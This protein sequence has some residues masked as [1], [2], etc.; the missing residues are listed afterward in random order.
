MILKRIFTEMFNYGMVMVATSNRAPD[1]LYKN[2]LQRVNFLP[3]IPILKKHCDVI[4]IFGKD[5]RLSIA[6]DKQERY[7]MLVLYY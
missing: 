2:G 1:D 6:G 5:F 4:E 7:L 3:F